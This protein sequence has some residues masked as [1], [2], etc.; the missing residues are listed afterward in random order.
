MQGALQ[1]AG[2]GGN[3]PDPPEAE[4]HHQHRERHQRQAEGGDR[5]QVDADEG[6]IEGRQRQ[7]ARDVGAQHLMAVQSV[8]Q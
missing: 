5:D 6:Q 3:Q 2:K 8:G 1:G 7:W 4:Q